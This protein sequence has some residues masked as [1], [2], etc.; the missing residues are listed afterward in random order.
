MFIRIML[1]PCIK[2]E[3]RFNACF[4]FFLFFFVFSRARTCVVAN[5][6][7]CNRAKFS[8]SDK[9]WSR[10]MTCLKFL[11][12]VCVRAEIMFRVWFWSN[13]R[14]WGMAWLVLFGWAKNN[15]RAWVYI[16][17]R[18]VSMDVGLNGFFFL[19]EKYTVTL[20]LFPWDASWVD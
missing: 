13:V 16:R 18:C 3:I 19:A 2:A 20:K 6:V 9:F 15:L 17:S 14:T 10:I 5:F 7:T 4:F 12:G 8:F 1:V 11:L